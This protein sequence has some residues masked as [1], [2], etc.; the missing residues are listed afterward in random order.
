MEEQSEINI[1]L[2]LLFN[3]KKE[4]SN[5]I[6]KKIGINQMTVYNYITGRDPSYSFLVKILTLFQDISAEWL[7]LGE[8]SMYKQT[9]SGNSVSINTMSGGNAVAGNNASVE[10]TT[11]QATLLKEKDDRIAELMKDKEHLTK[12]VELLMNK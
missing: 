4:N 3:A 5:S 2:N 9:A 11:D 8:G 7:M 12:L 1:R 10:S 6:A